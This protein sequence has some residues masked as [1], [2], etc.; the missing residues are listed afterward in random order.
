MSVQLAALEALLEVAGEAP[1]GFAGVYAA[2]MPWLRGFLS[3]TDTAGVLPSDAP[4]P[5]PWLAQRFLVGAF[6]LNC[7]QHWSKNR[8]C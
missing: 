4:I 6:L 1:E 5:L 3:H 2:R 8:T 7:A